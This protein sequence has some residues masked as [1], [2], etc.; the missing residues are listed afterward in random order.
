MIATRSHRTLGLLDVVGREQDR[1]AVALLRLDDVPER[2]ASSRVEPG[3]GLVEEHELGLVDQRE[4]D[5]QP[6]SL[7][8]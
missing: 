1:P 2:P 4:G 7:T 8:A 5:G 6:L 3:R